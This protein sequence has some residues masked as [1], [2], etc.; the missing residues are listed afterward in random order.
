MVADVEASTSAAVHLVSKATTVKS[1]HPDALARGTCV[2]G[3]VAMESAPVSTAACVTKDGTANFVIVVSCSHVLICN[4]YVKPSCFTDRQHHNETEH[5]PPP[6]RRK[7]W[8]WETEGLRK[9]NIWP[10]KLEQTITSWK[11]N[12]DI[13]SRTLPDSLLFSNIWNQGVSHTMMVTSC[14]STPI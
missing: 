6:R 2:S 3:H 7:V 8:V 12:S 4:S 10:H 13:S 11:M 9:C 5:R 14:K 1:F